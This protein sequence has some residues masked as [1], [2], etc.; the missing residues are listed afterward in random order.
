MPKITIDQDACISC[1]ACA[2]V[3]PDLFEMNDENKSQ[4]KKEDLTAEE[5]TQAKEGA[6]TCPVQAIKVED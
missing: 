3:A 6:Q 5:T 4:A 2:A 1:G